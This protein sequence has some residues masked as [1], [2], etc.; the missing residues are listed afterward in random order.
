MAYWHFT[1]HLNAE[2]LMCCSVKTVVMRHSDNRN[3]LKRLD[4]TI[5]ILIFDGFMV[6]FVVVKNI[7]NINNRITSAK[8]G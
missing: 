7:L 6:N 1:K 3:Q 2:L 4:I 8:C 5:I